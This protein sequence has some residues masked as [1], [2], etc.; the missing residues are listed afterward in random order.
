MEHIILFLKFLIANLIPDTPSY[1]ARE[2]AR[3]QYGT[4]RAFVLPR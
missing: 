2:L 4:H 1:I 3:Q